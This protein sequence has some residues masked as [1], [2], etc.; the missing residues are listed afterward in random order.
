MAFASLIIVIL[1]IIAPSLA[2]VALSQQSM[3][4]GLGFDFIVLISL[5]VLVYSRKKSYSIY[6]FNYSKPFQRFVLVLLAILIHGVFTL[7]I[8][9]AASAIRF[10]TGFLLFIMMIISS[11]ALVDILNKTSKN[12][13]VF[14][15]KAL[16]VFFIICAVSAL[17]GLRFFDNMSIKPVLIFAEPSHFVLILSPFLIFLFV[18]S[19]T[20]RYYL[21]GF[22][23]LW[24]GSI[25]SLTAVISLMICVGLVFKFEARYILFVCLSIVF[26]IILSGDYYVERFNF[27]GESENLSV[28]VYLQGWENAINGLIETNLIGLGFQQFGVYHFSGKFYNQLSSLGLDDINIYDGSF[29]AAKIIGEFG[30]FGVVLLIIFVFTFFKSFKSLRRYHFSM[31]HLDIFFHSCIL[32]FIVELFVRGVGYFSPSLF[33]AISAIL[34]FQSRKIHSKDINNITIDN[35]L[36][37]SKQQFN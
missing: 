33:L 23:L 9:D 21:F 18:I 15:S 37:F 12:R 27:S 14:Y 35:D 2:M 20:L 29:T 4:A 26:S 19:S 16:M 3:A 5:W 31:N 36:S 34:Y 32:A 25:G 1:L 6:L 7:I 30:V 22:F 8:E 10:A 13:F 24:A 17:F 28:L 11:P